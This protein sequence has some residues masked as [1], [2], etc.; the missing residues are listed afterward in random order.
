[1]M[2]MPVLMLSVPSGLKPN[3]GLRNG[4]GFHDGVCGDASYGGGDAACD[5]DGG[6]VFCAG[7]NGD[8]VFYDVY[9]AFCDG[10][11]GDACD[12]VCDGVCGLAPRLPYRSLR[13]PW[14]R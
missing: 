8:D 7:N 10:V 12:G 13:S 4:D 2:P 3:D 6:G 5:S 9:G 14:L 11:C 1:M